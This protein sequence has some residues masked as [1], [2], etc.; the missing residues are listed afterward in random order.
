MVTLV[1]E[2]LMWPGHTLFRT[3]WKGDL[4]IPEDLVQ[5]EM[6]FGSTWVGCHLWFSAVFFAL[7]RFGCWLSHPQGICPMVSRWL[8]SD[9]AEDIC[10]PVWRRREPCC[11]IHRG[12]GYCPVMNCHWGWKVGIMILEIYTPETVLLKPHGS[13]TTQMKRLLRAML[14]LGRKD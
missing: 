10:L 5:R 7:S 3:R 9:Q 12:F 8:P 13:H 14:P 4:A 2:A 11:H 6:T 1:S